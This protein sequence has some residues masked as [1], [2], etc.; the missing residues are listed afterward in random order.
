M[1]IINS[2]DLSKYKLLKNIKN[3][4]NIKNK[5]IYSFSFEIELIQK[6]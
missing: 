5:K 6:N 1:D 4:K 3:I 2:F